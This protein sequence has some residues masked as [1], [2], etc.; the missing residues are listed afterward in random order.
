MGLISTKPP[1]YSS[2]KPLLRLSR[3]GVAQVDDLVKVIEETEA[4]RQAM[5]EIL[6]SQRETATKRQRQQ[7]LEV[8]LREVRQRLEHRLCRNTYLLRDFNDA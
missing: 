5:R 1:L 6:F 4:Q 2:L 8:A 3:V 7:Q